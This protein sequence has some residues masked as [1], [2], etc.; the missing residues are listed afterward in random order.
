MQILRC[1]RTY[2]TTGR[3]RRLVLPV[4]DVFFLAATTTT[5]WNSDSSTIVRII[6][7]SV[8]GC[9]IAL[10]SANYMYWHSQQTHGGPGVT[11]RSVPRARLY[12]QPFATKYGRN[13]FNVSAAVIKLDIWRHF[14]GTCIYR[15]AQKSSH[16]IAIKPLKPCQWD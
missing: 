11:N 7:G 9:L 15:A 2:A 5:I 14:V 10:R 1:Q 8:I 13:W 6:C 4:R 16:Y 12:P 3:H